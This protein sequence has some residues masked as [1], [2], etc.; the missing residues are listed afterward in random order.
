MSEPTTKPLL[1]DIGVTGAYNKFGGI[2]IEDILDVDR[3]Y[4]ASILSSPAAAR[5][6]GQSRVF[7]EELWVLAETETEELVIIH[8]QKPPK[9]ATLATAELLSPAPETEK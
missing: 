9:P 6:K 4:L 8:R 5:R 3:G 1:L 7:S 2:V